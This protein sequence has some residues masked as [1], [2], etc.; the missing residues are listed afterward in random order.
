MRVL[1]RVELLVDGIEQ[2]RVT[3]DDVAPVQP[4]VGSG[5]VSDPTTSF[6]DEQRTGGH[7]V[8]S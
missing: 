6:L 4:P 1:P 2:R 5:E 7:V 3:G 8:G